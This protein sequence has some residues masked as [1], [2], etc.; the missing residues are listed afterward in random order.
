MASLPSIM[1]DKKVKL[2][3]FVA[4]DGEGED[5]RYTV[6]AAS[7]G[8]EL[9]DR[10]GLSSVDCLNFLLHSKKDA[11]NIWYS[12]GYDV[13]MILKDI[14]FESHNRQ[15]LRTLREEAKIRWDGYHITYIPGK[16]F[17]VWKRED[18]KRLVY[19]AYDVFSF[20]QKRF[21]DVAITWL[22]NVP[23][24][25]VKGK[26]GREDFTNWKIEDI[27]QY[28]RAELEVLVLLMEE[29]RRVVYSTGYQVRYWY[30]PGAAAAEWLRVN[31][32]DK[33]I[34]ELPS[35]MEDPVSRAYFAG[36]IDDAAWGKAERIFH[37][38]IN[39][40]Y[41]Y[42]IRDLPSLVGLDW[43]LCQGDSEE[44]FSLRRVSWRIVGRTDGLYQW[45]V[46]PYR[47]RDGRILFPLQGHGWY[48][49]VEVEAAKRYVA[50]LHNGS[51]LVVHESWVPKGEL[52]YP[53]REPVERDAQKRI[54]YKKKGDPAHWVLKLILNSLYGKLAQRIRKASAT[55]PRYQCYAWAGYV[56]AKTR[57]MLL[58][59]IR[60]ANGK[61][62][63]VMTDSIWSL[64]PLE[65]LD[66]GEELGQWSY[67]QDHHSATF[68]GAGL[69]QVR[70]KKGELVK[71]EYRSRGFSVVQ[72]AAFDYDKIVRDWE[73]MLYQGKPGYN[74][75]TVNR[76]FVG[77]SLA[78]VSKK[79]RESF[80]RFINIERELNPLVWLGHT[81]REGYFVK[82]V[83]PPQDNPHLHF[84]K[85]LPIE[86]LS[87]LFPDY[88]PLSWP[89]KSFHHRAVKGEEFLVQ[90]ALMDDDPS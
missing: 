83:T 74:L 52:T 78:A 72:G 82:E 35:D 31:G 55:T 73:E 63:S 14:P 36:R 76:R 45:G 41:P 75:F 15:D 4:F 1:Y 64:I 71:S 61:I 9:V 16:V 24:I 26:E 89:Y 2:R 18:G 38:D 6:L 37:Y 59:A 46:L 40:A 44:D 13:A 8:R 23:D 47:M 28:N 84:M 86:D 20:F 90:D 49:G 62:V 22:G 66:I 85:P 30:G 10:T 34:A 33:H 65:D 11:I 39:S 32:I 51:E 87:P 69:Y 43:Q 48:W 77:I 19:T 50:S 67:E 53:F 12:F 88:I 81:K 25:I 70:D 80:C 29:F 58:D 27:V 60:L 79:Y 5:G 17:E 42:A 3:P 21:T 54:E 68:C 7:D 57:S 56:T